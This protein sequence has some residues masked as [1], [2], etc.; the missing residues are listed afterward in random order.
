MSTSRLKQQMESPRNLDWSDYLLTDR[1]LSADEWLACP[2]L[3]SMPV[4]GNSGVLPAPCDVPAAEWKSIYRLAFDHYLRTGRLVSV[5]EGLAACER[6]FNP[7]HDELGRFTFA[8]GG[9]GL[10]PSAK[11]STPP[12]KGASKNGQ[13][14]GTRPSKQDITARSHG[15]VAAHASGRTVTF[16]NSDGSTYTVTGNHP[17][18][19]NNPLDLQVGRAAT[20][21]GSIGNDKGFAIFPNADDGSAAAVERMG[22]IAKYPSR[23]GQPAGSLANIIYI[24]SPPNENDTEGMISDITRWTGLNRNTKYLSMTPNQKLSFVHAYAKREGY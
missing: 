22:R 7:Y 3:K 14:G 6:K 19:D 16:T 18:R 8:P 13:T 9:A 10:T 15:P 24:W 21:N 5:G 11:P 2:E 12:S 4:I 17:D 20:D 1:Q 23:S